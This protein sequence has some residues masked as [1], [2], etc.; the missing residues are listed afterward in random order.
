MI[1][2]IFFGLK[3]SRNFILGITAFLYVFSN[4][5]ISN[6]LIRLIEYPWERIDINAPKS[7]DAIVVLSG[8]RHLPPGDSKIIEW[9]DPDRFLSGIDLYKAGKANNLIFTGGINPYLQKIPPEG[10]LYIKEAESMGIPSKDLY[11]T[12]PVVN[13]A[14]EAKAI[15]IKLKNIINKKSPNIILVTSAFHMQRAKKLFERE[16][17][18]VYPYPVD[19]K[20][21]KI[22]YKSL[23]LNP[24]YWV[25]NSMILHSSSIAIREIIGRLFYKTWK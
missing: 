12:Y 19:F 16:S 18:K 8:G 6:S 1:F 20:S 7:A 14:E 23:L 15:K 2:L 4:G 11:T 13:T 22:S 17:I 25:P 3:K 24:L 9:Y 10:D 21:Q 5:I